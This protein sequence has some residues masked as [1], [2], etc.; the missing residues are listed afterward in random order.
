MKAQIKFIKTLFCFFSLLAVGE[1]KSQIFINEIMVNPSGPNDGANMPNTAEWIEFYNGFASAIDI[2]CWFFTDGDFAVTFPSVTSIPAGGYYIVASALGSGLTP[3]LDWATCGC[4]S[5]PVSQVGIL[6]NSGE[7]VLLYDA[8]GVI[9]DA[10]IW[11]GG[12]LPDGIVTSV[13]GTCASQTVTFPASGATYENIGTGADGIAQERATDGSSTWQNTSS[14]TA[15]SSNSPIVLPIELIEFK[16]YSNENTVD[17]IWQTATEINNDFFTVERSADAVNFES[18][19]TIV[20]AGN[21]SQILSYS[22]TDDFPL[23][24]IS[25]YRL[26]QTDFN[27]ISSYS[28]IVSVVINNSL[29]ISVE[30]VYPNPVNDKLYIEFNGGIKESLSIKIVNSIGQTLLMENKTLGNIIPIDLTSFSKGIYMLI[31][32]GDKYFYQ[33]K[34]IKN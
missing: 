11:S 32:S 21:S 18:I 5:G 30:N 10:V 23:K 9:V 29:G 14:P 8:A 22:T 34:I 33:N 16:A 2:S 1:A 27:G 7:Q 19:A 28:A 12:Q 13:V 15:G 6:T 20:G 17:L 4:T 3:N 31:I 26:K 25:Y 24:K